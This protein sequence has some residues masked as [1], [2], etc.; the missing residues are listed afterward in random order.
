MKTMWLALLL[1]AAPALAEPPRLELYTARADGS[2]TVGADGRVLDVALS[3]SVDLGK[4]V[5]AG[6]EERIRAWRF[7]PIVEN[8]QPVNAKGRMH[9]SLVALR[10]VGADSATFGIRSVQFLDPP[11]T[12][13]ADAQPGLKAPLYP[14]NGLRAGAGAD[15]VVLV[16]VD[17]QGQVLSAAT[18]TLELLGVASRQA[19]QKQLAAQFRLEAERTALAWVLPGLEA[20]SMARVPVRFT[21]DRMAGWTSTVPQAVELPEWAALELASEQ[22]KDFSASGLA[23]AEQFRLLT[24]LD[25]A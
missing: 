8:G 1:S 11:G 15:L 25:G 16:K 22:V 18:E 5:L 14:A 24:P 2:L 6:F 3:S 21:T 4:D 12:A 17:A 19:H 9:L 20:G 23:S 10:E 7:E 13:P